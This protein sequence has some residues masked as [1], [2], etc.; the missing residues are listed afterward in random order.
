MFSAARHGR[1][2]GPR[3]LQERCQPLQQAENVASRSWL[4]KSDKPLVMV[5]KLYK[6]IY[7]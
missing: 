7:I 2:K 6:G 5:L 4:I 3:L 1:W